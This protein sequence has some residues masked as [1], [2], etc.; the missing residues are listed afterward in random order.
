MIQKA[1]MLW[2]A[3]VMTSRAAFKRLEDA[4]RPYSLEFKD[5]GSGAWIPA[6]PPT[7]TYQLGDSGQSKPPLWV[8]VSWSVQSR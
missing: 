3:C 7:T 8:W 4:E 1:N 6:V 2:E 5:M